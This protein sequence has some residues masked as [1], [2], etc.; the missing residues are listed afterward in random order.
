M[1]HFI[2]LLCYANITALRRVFK[3]HGWYH[4]K[5]KSESRDEFPIKLTVDEFPIK[6]ETAQRNMMLPY[7]FAQTSYAASFQLRQRRHSLRCVFDCSAYINNH[8]A[9]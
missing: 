8:T 3:L 6:S 1:E 2:A 4:R 9:I 5:Y 7:T